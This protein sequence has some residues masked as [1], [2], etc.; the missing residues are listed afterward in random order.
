MP[1]LVLPELGALIGFVLL[2]ILAAVLWM[3]SRLLVRGF[4]NIP[5]VGS[6]I[7]NELAGWVQDAATEIVNDA[8]Q[9]FAYG[10][11]LFQAL[12]TGVTF[13]FGAIESDFAAA[14]DSIDHV[15]GVVVPREVGDLR[16]WADGE[17]TRV[18]DDARALA[19]AA[20]GTAEHDLTALR[21]YADQQLGL[22][23]SYAD[24]IVA[25]AEAD[26][27][28]LFD[29]AEADAANALAR[30]SS[31]LETDIV[32]AERDAS[33]AIAAASAVAAAQLAA[34]RQGIYTDLENWGDQAVATAWPDAAGDLANLRKVLGGDFPWLNDLTGALGGL[35]VAGL[36]GALIRSLAT[37][38][39][40]TN[41]AADCTVPT[42]RNLS[43]FG[44]DL[45]SLLGTAS[46]AAFLAWL[47]FGIADPAAWA[48]DT[49]AAGGVIG[50]DAIASARGLLG[51]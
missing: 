9:V 24:S 51:L 47:V 38:N 21:A 12:E 34:V 27:R 18:E 1:V 40:L 19:S 30:A 36:A 26:A 6:W 29:T 2:M 5:L 49:A 39:A 10:V 43:Q 4:S 3:L 16:A 8:H 48:Q 11:R 22:L 28:S 45:A 14:R 17:L 37:S 20:L 46:T 33:S 31:V 50:N 44:N 41:L 7:G 32:T 35:G 15:I 13:L 23:R 42:C 25:G